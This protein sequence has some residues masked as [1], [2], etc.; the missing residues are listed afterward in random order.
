M[1]K[2]YVMINKKTGKASRKF[3]TREQARAFKRENGF[4][5]SIL[6]A[7]TNMVVR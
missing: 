4:K 2:P 6:N 5:Y 3:T 7:A 1:T